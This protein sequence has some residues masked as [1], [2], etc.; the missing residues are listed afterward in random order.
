MDN[1][2]NWAGN[3]RYNSSE[4]LEPASLEEVRDMIA[5]SSRIRALGSRHSFNGIAD[6]D[7]SQLSLRKLN[8]VIELDRE[9]GTVTVEGGIRYGE[10]CRHLNDQ[11]YALHNLA[12]LPHISVA[13]AVATATH[14]SGDRNAG[15]ADA[16]HTIELVKANGEVVVLTRGTDIEFEG[17]VV[18]LGALGVVTKLKLNVVPSYP[19]CQTVYDQL[20]LSALDG[21][22]EEIFSAAYSVSLFTDWT[23]SVFNQAWVKRKVSGDGADGPAP[24]S[25]DFF[26]ASQASMKRH[27]VPGQSAVNCSEQS[28]V[29]G[30]WYERL[31]HFRMDFTPSAGHELQSE[32]FVPRRH[33]LEALRALD[34]MRERIAP[35]LFISEV[36]T[37]A[38]DEFWMSPCYRQ[39]SVGLHFT[40]KPEWERVR[41]LL[42]LIE[43]ELE[44][45]GARPHWAKL[46]TMEPGK[47][48]AQCERLPDFRQLLL[49]YDPEGK[50]RNSFMDTY[51]MGQ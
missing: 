4:L 25:S 13:G 28:G 27:P 40:W 9:Q 34:T 11:G 33:A 41:E 14:G 36:R 30:P 18:G 37:I 5:R 45:F 26:G 50:F 39:D 1:K 51:I 22:F 2:L 38:A 16:V 49:R 46:F 35:L 42:P 3:Y 19:I 21:N 23:S 12:S 7:G 43:R 32:Y 15:L 8:Q 6:T 10:L 31:P 48:Q 29:P 24:L 17:A 20:P 47:V 44:P